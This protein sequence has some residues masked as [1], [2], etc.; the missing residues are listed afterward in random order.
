MDI[1]NWLNGQ[2]EKDIWSKKY[3]YE[4][5]T[6]DEWLNRV[7]N[8]NQAMKEIIKNKEGLP[9]GRILA[10]RGLHKKGQKVTYSNCYVT[11]KPK[12]N[13]ESIFDTAKRLARTFSYGGGSGL[14]VSNLRPRGS[15]VSNAAEESTG[16][17]SFMDLYS[18]VT[19][20]IGQ[21][22][23]RGALMLMMDVNHPDLEE[24][25]GVKNDLDRVTKANI[26]V[27]IDDKFMRKAKYNDTHRLT[28]ETEHGETIEKKVDAEDILYKIAE[29]NWN[30]GEPGM[31]FWD[32]FK[33]WSIVSDDDKFK[34]AATNP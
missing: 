33:N 34:Y 16:A 31:L 18:M 1:N 8:G 30:T 7:T 9:A 29:S 11:S 13:L 25:I 24:F 21:K 2:L 26:S 4:D 3:Q 28:F 20:V 32:R 5:E 17:V 15:N 12:D 22:N 27:K 19:G 23:R 10:N 14:D 6:F